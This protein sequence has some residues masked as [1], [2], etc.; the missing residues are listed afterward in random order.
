M[1]GGY[2]DY[3]DYRLDEF[4]GL[5]DELITDQE[6]PEYQHER[7]SAETLLIF[8]VTAFQLRR[9]AVTVNRI[10]WLVC[11]DD[12]EI[13]FHERLQEELE[14]LTSANKTGQ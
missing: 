1:S 9:M 13:E 3:Q 11:G 10:D 5:I 2:F 6:D 8:K 12:G 14:Q 4:A 7:Y